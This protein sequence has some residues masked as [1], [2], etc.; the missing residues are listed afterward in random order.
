MRKTDRKE[1]GVGKVYDGKKRSEYTQNFLGHITN[2]VH[3]TTE[4]IE[5]S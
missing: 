3:L 2:A 1:V 4:K 5:I